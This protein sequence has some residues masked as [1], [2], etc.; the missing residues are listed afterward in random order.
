MDLVEFLQAKLDALR[1]NA[2]VVSKERN[3]DTDYEK[4][5]VV[6]SALSGNIYKEAGSIPYQIEIIT[7]DIN[8]VM[9]DFTTLAR[10]N[11]NVSTTQVI[12]TGEDT[13]QSVTITPFF[14]TPVVMDKELELGSDKYARIVVWATVN[15]QENVNNIKSLE[16][17]GEELELLT[18]T[19]AYVV[20]ADPT[21]VSGDELSKSK[22]RTSS[23]SITFST[24]SKSS[25]FLNKGF[26]IATGTLPGNTCFNV[27]VG[28]D[29]GL[30]AT[31]KMFIGSYNFNNERTKLP[32]V[33][34]GLFLY[35]DR[36]D[37]NATSQD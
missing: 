31:L 2:Y 17:D 22:K 4:Y 13:Y 16:I 26:K 24:I 36:G 12:Q 19:L 9:A 1:P 8:V 14:N 33:N 6:V 29:N 28:L 3:V 18:G 20:E 21:R 11:N 25:V 15:E 34:V 5:Q 7:N 27:V 23:C 30:S 35:D 32:L 37:T 10:N